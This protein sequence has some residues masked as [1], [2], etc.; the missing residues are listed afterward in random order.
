LPA[1]TII[2]RLLDEKGEPVVG[3]RIQPHYGGQEA[4][5]I[6]LQISPRRKPVLTDKEG[7][8]RLESVIPNTN[9][10]MLQSWGGKN[11]NPVPWTPPKQVAPGEVLDVGDV[12]TRGR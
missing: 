10:P 9:V 2:G 4:Q 12:P 7:R 1:G 3:V 5:G 11:L 6:Q 8:F